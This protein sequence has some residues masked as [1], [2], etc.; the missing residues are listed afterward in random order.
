MVVGKNLE[1]PRTIKNSLNALVSNEQQI[2]N[3][4]GSVKKGVSN[5]PKSAC[6]ADMKLRHT[7]LFFSCAYVGTVWE[8]TTDKLDRSS[9]PSGDSSMEHIFKNWW[10]NE[11]VCNNEALPTLFVFTIWKA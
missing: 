8:R 7:H 4:G 2:A 6:F 5:G 11:R 10:H 9:N 1:D 3:M